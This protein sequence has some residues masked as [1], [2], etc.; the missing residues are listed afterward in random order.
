M[1]SAA[2]LED[3]GLGERPMWPEAGAVAGLRRRSG[4]VAV[5]WRR[6]EQVV[7]EG[8]LGRVD[9][10][11]VCSGLVQDWGAGLV[12]GMGDG[13]AKAGPRSRLAMLGGRES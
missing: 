2:G 5:A 3:S 10:F 12:P 1:L 13:E 11:H 6:I 9:P 8:W 7:R 4:W